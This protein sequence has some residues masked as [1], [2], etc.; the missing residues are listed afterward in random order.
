MVQ[1]QMQVCGACGKEVA[2][3]IPSRFWEFRDRKM[4]QEFIATQ[5]IKAIDGRDGATQP[6]PWCGQPKTWGIRRL[7]PPS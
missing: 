4:A 2:V 3:Q 5:G 6:C 1:L 7:R